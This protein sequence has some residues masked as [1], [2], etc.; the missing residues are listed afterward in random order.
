MPFEVRM[1]KGPSKEGCRAMWAC[2]LEVWAVSVSGVL[3]G[4]EGMERLRG[5]L[6]VCAS[7]VYALVCGAPCRS[8]TLSMGLRY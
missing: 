5:A 2:A 3:C 4:W 1:E 8:T 6:E 7:M